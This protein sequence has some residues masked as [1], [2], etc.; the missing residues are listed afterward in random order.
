[1]LKYIKNLNDMLL[2]FFA[3]CLGVG[4]IAL[5]YGLGYFI[6]VGTIN[7]EAIYALTQDDT[8]TYLGDCLILMSFGVM[9]A[10]L[11]GKRMET[12][13]SNNARKQ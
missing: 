4:F 3:L 6:I 7:P 2:A 1:M 10:E 12:R 5:I 9:N 11:Y 13:R 8:F